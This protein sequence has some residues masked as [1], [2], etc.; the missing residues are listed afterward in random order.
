MRRLKT[1]SLGTLSLYTL[2]S[3]AAFTGCG[4]SVKDAPL[5]P[6]A[7]KASQGAQDGMKAFMQQKAQAKSKS[8]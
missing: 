3:L 2:L 6:D 8:K 4:D 7:Q 1:V 5:T